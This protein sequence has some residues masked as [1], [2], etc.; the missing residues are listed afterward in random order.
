[1]LQDP[2]RVQ[3]VC[4]VSHPI[5]HNNLSQLLVNNIPN[6]LRNKFPQLLANNPLYRP[7]NNTRNGWQQM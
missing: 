7:Q 1:M 5:E 4:F 2:E 6:P 3:E